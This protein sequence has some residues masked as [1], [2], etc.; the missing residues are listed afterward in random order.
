M[1]VVSP[2][3]NRIHL[4]RSS[5]LSA[6]YGGLACHRATQAS[7][8]GGGEAVEVQPSIIASAVQ[9]AKPINLF[10]LLSFSSILDFKAVRP[11]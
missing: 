6:G 11:V 3:A 8:A 9:L 7:S 5:T 2:S 1:I 10:M 4:T